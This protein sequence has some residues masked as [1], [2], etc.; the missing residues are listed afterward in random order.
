MS[1]GI[2][3]EAEDVSQEAPEPIEAEPAPAP[4]RSN[5]GKSKGGRP[6]G[7]KAKGPAPKKGAGGRKGQP[8]RG[9]AEVAAPAVGKP[10]TAAALRKAR[11]EESKLLVLQLREP[12]LMLR[13][14]GDA[15]R[16][17]VLLYLAECEQNVGELCA[18]INQS[19]PAVSHHLALLRH[20][21]LLRPRRDGKNNYYSLTAR[22]KVMARTIRATMESIG[23]LD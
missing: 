14:L 21:N 18:K 8:A 15:T 10:P 16:C 1:V 17:S 4:A 23:K 22:G 11:A 13:Q 12:V 7:S 19:Q 9:A 5:G 3:A 6:K 2:E 20:S